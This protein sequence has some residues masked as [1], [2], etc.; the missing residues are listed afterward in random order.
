M[1][2]VVVTIPDEISFANTMTL[3]FNQED[4]SEDDFTAVV[5][6]YIMSHI[7]IEIL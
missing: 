3:E 5:I 4:M 1:R 7:Q 6:D 2:E